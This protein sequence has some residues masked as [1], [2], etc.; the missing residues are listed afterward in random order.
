MHSV[1]PFSILS[2]EAKD[3]YS[4][5]A[6]IL[7]NMDNFASYLPITVSQN[8]TV[9]ASEAY[10]QKKKEENHSKTTLTFALKDIASQKIAGLVIVKNINLQKKEAEFAYCLGSTYSGN[11]WMTKAIEK[12]T[13]ITHQQLDIQLFKIIT[14]KTNISSCRVAEKNGFIW[15]KTLLKAFKPKG[16]APMDMELYERTL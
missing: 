4:L 7:D 14:H 16:V 3:A 8:L 2:L 13:E 15:K 10:I 5:N 6:L 1:G 12:I 9:K 11:G